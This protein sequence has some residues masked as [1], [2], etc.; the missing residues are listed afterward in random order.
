[1]ENTAIIVLSV[2]SVLIVPFARQFDRHV[3]MPFLRKIGMQPEK[4][5][6]FN[7][8]LLR[9]GL[10]VAGCGILIYAVVGWVFIVIK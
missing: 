7:P 10:I 1:M 3:Y 8:N 6:E 2:L 9:L 4:S 5:V